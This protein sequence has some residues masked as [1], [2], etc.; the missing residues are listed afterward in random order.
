MGLILA[1]G[2]CARNA[3]VRK[4]ACGRLGPSLPS[5]SWLESMVL[6]CDGESIWNTGAG[7]IL[8]LGECGPG[9]RAPLGVVARGRE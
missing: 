4:D 5:L 2:V 7:I 6:G 9:S 1:P 8:Q 3:E